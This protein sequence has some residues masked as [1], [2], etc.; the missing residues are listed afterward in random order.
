MKYP[1]HAYKSYEVV[2]CFHWGKE[3]ARDQL[4]HK[5]LRP[6]WFPSIES[7]QTLPRSRILLEARSTRLGSQPP[8]VP[9]RFAS[10]G[11]HFDLPFRE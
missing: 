6:C 10:C 5:A 8:L 9:R 1:I 11:R 2:R 4:H 7:N 3:G